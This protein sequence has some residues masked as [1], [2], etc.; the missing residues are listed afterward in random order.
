MRYYWRGPKLRGMHVPAISGMHAD[1]IDLSAV[2]DGEITL[3]VNK[4]HRMVASVTLPRWAVYRP[5]TQGW[6]APNGRV[7]Q[8]AI[9]ELIPNMPDPSM[10][11]E[12][13]VGVTTSPTERR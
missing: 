5:V 9:G 8:R 1:K 4:G 3:A 2:V 12:G 10:F 13:G 11:G 7:Y 6:T